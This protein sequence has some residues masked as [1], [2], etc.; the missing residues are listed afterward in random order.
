[1]ECHERPTAIAGAPII[2]TVR[3]VPGSSIQLLGS[4]LDHD[5]VTPLLVVLENVSGPQAPHYLDIFNV[6]DNALLT[7]EATGAGRNRI[8][9]PGSFD[10]LRGAVPT[11]AYRPTAATVCHGLIVIYCTVTRQPAVGQPYDDVGGAFVVSQNRGHTWSIAYE[12]P[13]FAPGWDRGAPWSMQNWWP[14]ARGIKPKQAYFVATDY[15]L[16]PGSPGGHTFMFR[17]TRP[18]P[19]A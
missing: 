14:T 19:G 13:E 4:G 9:L 18:K 6:A 7:A 12:S 2:E 15:C 1:M 11:K 5:G 16:N 10:L 3:H 8:V 17:A